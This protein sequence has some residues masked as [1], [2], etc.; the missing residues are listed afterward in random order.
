MS[1]EAYFQCNTKLPPNNN[2]CENIHLTQHVRKM[3]YGGGGGENYI[4]S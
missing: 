3:Y 2:F 4:F 1:I